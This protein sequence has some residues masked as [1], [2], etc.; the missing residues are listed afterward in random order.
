MAQSRYYKFRNALR[1]HYFS[2]N[3]KHI[4]W[5]KKLSGGYRVG[6]FKLELDNK[7]GT[8][9]IYVRNMNQANHFCSLCLINEN[10]QITFHYRNIDEIQWILKSNE[11]K[12]ILIINKIHTS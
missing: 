11:L 7:N 12:N 8:H 5:E 6:L 2:L 3:D 1:E 9:E 4:I 10:G